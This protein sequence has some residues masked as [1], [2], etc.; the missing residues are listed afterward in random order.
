MNASS[1]FYI[2][3][4]DRTLFDSERSVEL[5]RGIVALYEPDVASLLA[6]RF[7][8]YE[9]QGESFSVRDFIADNTSEADMQKIESKYYEMAA[10]QDFLY[11]GAS[12]LIAYI[13]EKDAAKIAILTYGSELGQAM[14]IK[15]SPQ[16]R[17]IP[18]LVTSETYKGALIA[19]WRQDDD[20][21]HL[22]DEYGGGTAKTIVFVDDKPFSFKGLPIDCR[23]YW[24]KSVYDAGSEM[25][26]S[27]VKPIENLSQVI[28]AEKLLSN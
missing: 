5:M 13:Q 28:V 11:P 26:P 15:A 18:F 14:K 21:Y 3:D 9:S 7:D 8:E 27:Y 1:T 17:N 10:A 16:L 23:G 2:V 20:L 24:V 22:P 25:L 12:E 6:Q 4:L 19:S